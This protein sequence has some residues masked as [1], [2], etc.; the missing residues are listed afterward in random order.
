MV[1]TIITA[2][3]RIT[4]CTASMKPRDQAGACGLGAFHPAPPVDVALYLKNGDA[5]MPESK[6][7]RYGMDSRAEGRQAL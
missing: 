5:H 3:S 2:D 7:K 1:A 4:K 6:G